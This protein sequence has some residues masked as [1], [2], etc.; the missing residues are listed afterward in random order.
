MDKINWLDPD[1]K[2]FTDDQDNLPDVITPQYGVGLTFKDEAGKE[3][4]TVLDKGYKRR[5]EARV[6]SWVG[7]MS[8]GAVHYYG[9]ITVH[10]LSVE[11]IEDGKKTTSSIGGAFDRHKPPETKT[12]DI[13]VKRRLTDDELTN[14]TM[15]D[16]ERFKGYKVGDLIDAFENEL[17]LYNAIVDIIKARFSGDWRVEIDGFDAD[18]YNTPSR[19]VAL[20]KLSHKLK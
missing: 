7:T 12:F 13:R 2:L 20:A 5:I 4:T 9:R 15:Y 11:Y 10:S 19:G 17:E 1:V 3:Y 8:Y 14:G 18:E 16:T 6:H